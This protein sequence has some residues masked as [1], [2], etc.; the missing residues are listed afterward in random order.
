[1]GG[2]AAARVSSRASTP[3]SNP[4]TAEQ[5]HRLLV[6][7]GP[8]R[9][10]R[11]LDWMAM[12]D[13]L[14]YPPEIPRSTSKP[15]RWIVLHE[16]W[17]DTHFSPRVASVQQTFYRLGDCH[18]RRASWHADRNSKHQSRDGEEKRRLQ[19]GTCQPSRRAT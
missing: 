2:P 5:S 4:T 19:I 6:R 3:G 8:P 9:P 7:D 13:V 15:V 10:Q 1:M 16:R 17:Q 12:R 18:F 11:A 14:P